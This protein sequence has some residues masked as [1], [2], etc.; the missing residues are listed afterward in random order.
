QA[1][2][3]PDAA[4]VWVGNV[5]DLIG[6]KRRKEKLAKLHERTREYVYYPGSFVPLAL[7]EKEQGPAL[8]E[9][10]QP[11]TTTSIAQISRSDAPPVA[12]TDS[13]GSDSTQPPTPSAPADMSP[14]Q[15]TPSAPLGVLASSAPKLAP[16]DGAAKH[17]TMVTRTAIKSG[18]PP[19]GGGLGTLG[20]DLALGQGAGTKAP[21]IA[22]ALLDP[23]TGVAKSDE[24]SAEGEQKP[25]NLVALGAWG[26]PSA[27]S[28]TQVAGSRYVAVNTSAADAPEVNALAAAD[29][30]KEELQF[31][32]SR[33]AESGG[34]RS[35]S[36][37]YQVDPNGCPTRM[38]NSA[39]ETVW[40]VNYSAWGRA[41]SSSVAEVENNI[42]YQ[43][44]YF[45]GESG[46]N[47]NRYR[48]FDTIAGQYVSRDPLGL[49]AGIDFYKYAPSST[50]WVDPLGL[51]DLEYTGAD[52]KGYTIYALVDKKSGD[53]KY[54]GLTED[55]RFWDRMNEHQ[56]SR[57]LHGELESIELNSARTYAEARGKEH[58]YIEKY[59]ETALRTSQRGKP[60][61]PGCEGN[62]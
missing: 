60:L 50:S 31:S 56:E 8:H 32:F 14:P 1:H 5:A 28:K 51:I 59:N 35:V 34:W 18:K 19:G 61:G 53:V 29:R 24:A 10:P 17:A 40:S 36:Y 4:P 21:V 2:D 37:H 54:V 22:G 45:D 42:R 44:Q 33:S 46:L 16:A 13:R 23:P 27:S 9:A 12:L 26:E 20:G 49:V 11:A 58:F 41:Y 7:I 47:Y 48:Y 38:T 62:M 55:S 15:R 57:R 6:V 43:G 30:A 52:G 3:E 39:G 25:S